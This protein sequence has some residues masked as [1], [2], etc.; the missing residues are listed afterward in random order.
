MPHLSPS[1]PTPST[2]AGFLGER[3]W[4]RGGCLV[5]GALEREQG[6][7]WHLAVCAGWQYGYQDV[8][9]LEKSFRAG[10]PLFPSLVPPRLPY[11]P[12]H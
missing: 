6:Q 4:R 3:V 8:T 5:Q 7:G 12:A 10:V 9:L 1:S 11:N 2:W